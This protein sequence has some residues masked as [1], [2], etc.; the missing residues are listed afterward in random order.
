MS[1]LFKCRLNPNFEIYSELSWVSQYLES[2]A[3]YKMYDK[4]DMDYKQASPN[5]ETPAQDDNSSKSVKNK[6]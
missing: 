1:N 5:Q 4:H 2:V 6:H 3:A